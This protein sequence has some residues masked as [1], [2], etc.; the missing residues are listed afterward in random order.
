M[1]RFFSMILLSVGGYFAY[2]N[3]FR[4]VNLVLGSPMIRKWFVSSLMSVPF[5]RD[6]M[7]KIVF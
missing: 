4:V 6:R 5:I 7:T 3:R 2:K 1:S